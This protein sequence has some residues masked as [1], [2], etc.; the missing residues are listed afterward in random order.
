V[1][2]VAVDVLREGDGLL[3]GARLAPHYAPA[4]VGQRRVE[5]QMHGT[6]TIP[7]CRSAFDDQRLT[8]TNAFA[9]FSFRSWTS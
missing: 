7:S 4:P 8:K 1:N 5:S 2:A 6:R 9:S 3:L